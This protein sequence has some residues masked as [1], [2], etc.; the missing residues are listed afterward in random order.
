M[1]AYY[2]FKGGTPN[3][4]TVATAFH[5]FSSGDAGA[6]RDLFLLNP[7]VGRKALAIESDPTQ[8]TYDSDRQAWV[9]PFIMSAINTRVVRRSCYLMGRDFAYQEFLTTE[10]RCKRSCSRDLA[11]R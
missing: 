8:A 4:G 9:A 3:G 2:K 7:E 11:Q 6:L 1:K 10:A 5:A